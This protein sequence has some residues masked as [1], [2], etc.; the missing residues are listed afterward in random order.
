MLVK[1]EISLT[2]SEQFVHGVLSLL[3]G[4]VTVLVW[5]LEVLGVTMGGFLTKDLGLGFARGVTLA[6]I[7]IPLVIEGDMEKSQFKYNHTG[8]FSLAPSMVLAHLGCHL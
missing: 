2:Y 5:G 8:S 4:L 1:A 6:R 7:F 3:L